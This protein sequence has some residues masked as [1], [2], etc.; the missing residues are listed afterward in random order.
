MR[1]LEPPA[2]DRTPGEVAAQAAP[3]HDYARRDVAELPAWHFE[4]HGKRVPPGAPRVPPP[5]RI[6][7]LLDDLGWDALGRA[8]LAELAEDSGPPQSPDPP[9]ARRG[10]RS[11]W[12]LP[13]DPG[14]RPYCPACGYRLGTIGHQV[15]CGVP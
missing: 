3:F 11:R 15:T 4:L 13:P 6:A 12:A 8:E 14:P 7:A 1:D 2:A 9:P 5:P 10:V